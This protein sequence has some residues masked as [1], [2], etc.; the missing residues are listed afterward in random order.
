M[1]L[2][3]D[4][5]AFIW[6]G[7]WSLATVAVLTLV[8]LFWNGIVGVFIYQL[9]QDFQWFL[10]FF[11][12]PF[13]AMGLFLAALWLAALTAPAWRLTWAFGEREATRRWNVSDADAIVFSFGWS[14]R[15]DIRPPIRIELRRREG[16]EQWGSLGGVLFQPDG[17]YDLAFLGR[18]DKPL[19]TIERLN[20][21]DARWIADTLLH[22]FSSWSKPESGVV[23]GPEGSTE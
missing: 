14:K 8:Q 16:K 6:T 22:A 5:V 2:Q 17:E 21:G 7:E 3:T 12:I 4:A 18:E 10:F 9:I 15:F 1:R 13:E 11:L 20:E 23:L 19:L